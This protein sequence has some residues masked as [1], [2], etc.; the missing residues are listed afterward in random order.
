[1]ET[2]EVEIS[3]KYLETTWSNIHHNE[4]LRNIFFS[5]YLTIAGGYIV[6]VEKAES[7]GNRSALIAIAFLIWI[8]G[9]VFNWTYIRLKGMI[10]RDSDITNILDVQF[11]ARHPS[12]KDVLDRRETYRAAFINRGIRAFGTVSTCVIWG[13]IVIGAL[14]PGATWAIIFPDKYAIG[15]AGFGLLVFVNWIA[16]R[17]V[18]KF[19]G[20]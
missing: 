12:L 10:D 20:Q 6:L 13:T 17:V 5:V 8:M 16:M 14:V 4:T 15:F 19:W 1:M 11:L 3:L 18:S 7:G 2:A 9:I